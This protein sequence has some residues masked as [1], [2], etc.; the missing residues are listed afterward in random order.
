MPSNQN[1][2]EIVNQNENENENENDNN[3]IKLN[4]DLDEIIDK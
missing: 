2:N 4:D 1:V 3:I